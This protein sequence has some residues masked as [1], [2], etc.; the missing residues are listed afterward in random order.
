MFTEYLLC[1]THSLGPQNDRE[2]CGEA[3]AVVQARGDSDLDQSGYHGGGDMELY[4]G[5]LTAL[6]I[7]SPVVPKLSL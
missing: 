6:K 1:A 3:N 7:S 2:F 4:P 5:Y